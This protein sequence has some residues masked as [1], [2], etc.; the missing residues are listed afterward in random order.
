MGQE[1]RAQRSARRG[2]GDKAGKMRR[3]AFL[4]GAG[5]AAVAGLAGWQLWPNRPRSGTPSPSIATLELLGD[6]GQVPPF[7]LTERSGRR[8]T[9]DDLSGLVWVLDFIY[10]ECNETCPTQSLQFARLEREFSDAADLRLVSITVDPVHDTPEV[11]S[12]YAERYG[13]SDRW[14]FLTGEKREIY[15]LA[16]EGFRLGIVDPAAADQ[17]AC[18]HAVR[19]GPTAA[20]ASHGSGGLIMHSA[21]FVLVDRRGHIR[22][23]HSATDTES[24]ARLRT[25]LDRIFGHA[26]RGSKDTGRG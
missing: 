11:L 1:A 20:R 21:R 17:P 8:V 3:R 6:Y 26:S 13:T 15:C 14:W 10:T 23:Y 5:A 4:Y 2:H 7:T 12:R 25:N 22:A 18:G 24:L 9:R 19:L 16:R